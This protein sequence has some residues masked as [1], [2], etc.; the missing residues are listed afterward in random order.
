MVMTETNDKTPLS[1]L[2]ARC[3]QGEQDALHELYEATADRLY[4]L[5]LR[6]VEHKEQAEDVLQDAFVRIYYRSISY[7]PRKAE[8]FH[9]MAAIVRNRAIESV[10]RRRRGAQKPNVGTAEWPDTDADALEERLESDDAKALFKCIQGIEDDDQRRALLL[11]FFD[12]LS[13]DEA[14]LRMDQP[15]ATVKGW[16]RGGLLQVKRCLEP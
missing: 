2:L 16:I 7:E 9:W 15:V 5:A 12:G 8:P 6:I 13:Y 4:G 11:A 10:R 14:A 1:E 3:G